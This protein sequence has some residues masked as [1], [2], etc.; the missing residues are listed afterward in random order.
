MDSDLGGPINLP[1]M[2]GYQCFCIIADRATGYSWV[3]LP[4]TKDEFV[5]KLEEHFL[6]M[7]KTQTPAFKIKRS[8]T[9]SETEFANKCV[10]RRFSNEGISWGSSAP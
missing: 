4:H 2:G 5:D 1:K 10:Q 8:R 7:V 6:L 3:Y 9:D